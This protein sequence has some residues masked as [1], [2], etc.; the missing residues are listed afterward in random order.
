MSASCSSSSRPQASFPRPSVTH[1]A[2][3]FL[4][5]P[6]P[7]WLF[8]CGK[9]AGACLFATL[10]ATLLI[11]GTW[12]AL[13]ISTADWSRGYL[14]CLPLLLTQFGVTFA[15]AVLLGVWTRNPLATSLGTFGFW[16]AGMIANY[17]HL[18]ASTEITTHLP[19]CPLLKHASQ[20]AY[21][22]LPKPADFMNLID[23]AI[24][25]AQH[26]STQAETLSPLQLGGFSPA[27]SVLTS[28]LVAVALMRAR[29]PR[30]EIAGIL[31]FPPLP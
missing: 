20:F 7:R 23:R 24:Q 28:T 19:G 3:A 12:L 15:A 21:W 10:L 9:V 25:S 29:R 2:P 22:L 13:G 18:A 11:G 6:T 17:A 1:S 27:L 26:V 16:G 5:H 14:L 30:A 4:V 8:L 31:A